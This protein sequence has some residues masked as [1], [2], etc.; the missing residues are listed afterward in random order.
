MEP[1]T[2]RTMFRC[3]ELLLGVPL[4]DTF[5]PA[6]CMADCLHTFLAQPELAQVG[7]ITIVTIITRVLWSS[8]V[9]AGRDAKR[10]MRGLLGKRLKP[11]P[12]NDLS[13]PPK[14]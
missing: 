3:V 4:W 7:A 14:A 9:D 10:L 8:A 1:A 6:T 12:V 11:Q 2:N 13:D 5:K